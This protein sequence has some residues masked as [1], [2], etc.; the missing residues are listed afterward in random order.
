[1]LPAAR[2]RDGLRAAFSG[3][4]RPF[5]FLWSGLLVTRA[6]NFVLPFLALYL[7]E[8]LHLPLRQAGLAI[9][10]YGAGGA[11]AGALGGYLADHIGRRATMLVALVGGGLS[12]IGLGM[13]RQPAVVLPGIFLVALVTEMSRPAMQAAVADLVAPAD[14]VRAFG[15]VYWVINVGF[16]IG[17]TLGGLL[18]SR[19]FTW[20]F[21]GDGVTTLAFALL[22]AIGVAETRPARTPHPPHEA[23]ARAWSEFFAPYRDR[24]FLLFLALGF[25]F[26]LVFMQNAT[27]FPVDMTAHGISKATY[28]G[29]LA[30]NGLVIVV[31]QPLLSPWLARWS[32]SHVMAVGAALVGLGFGLNAVV[33]TP[34][35][36]A[37][38]VV[39]WSVGEMGVLPVAFAVVSDLAPIDLR[40]RYQGA[41]GFAFGLAVTVAPALGMSVLGAW[42]S[43]A[44]WSGCLALGVLIAL[45]HLAL[46]R[47]LAHAHAARVAASA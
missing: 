1:M 24:Q 33:R 35:L 15:L 37:L 43:T 4:P 36:Y 26:A 30:L 32:R 20:L 27:T 8:A 21:I 17:L 7:T 46:A 9:G 11:L 23:R 31:A 6:G 13:S 39:I 44:L 5:W 14:R 47:G 18:A 34:P 22:I 2:V 19:S 38:G 45:G 3:L 29:V 28:G 25:L 42:G 12:M 40:G 16:A 41:Y 10:L